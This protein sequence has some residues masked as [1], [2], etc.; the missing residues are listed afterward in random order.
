MM[1][2]GLVIL[3]VYIPYFLYRW[4]SFFEEFRTAEKFLQEYCI[5][6]PDTRN[7]RG[8]TIRRVRRA[9]P[10][11]SSE[12]ADL[13]AL[14]IALRGCGWITENTSDF[15]RAPET[16]SRRVLIPYGNDL[17]HS[18][19]IRCRPT[20]LLKRPSSLFSFGRSPELSGF[21]SPVLWLGWN[22][23]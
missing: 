5:S 12:R 7:R 1:W 9:S 8:C 10:V 2:Q 17:P 11:V 19:T 15:P 22:D 20:W 23:R 13:R 3:L 18:G 4:K 16:P 6:F 14:E 21:P